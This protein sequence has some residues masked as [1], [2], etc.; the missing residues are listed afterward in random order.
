MSRLLNWASKEFREILPVW[1]FFFVSFA[2][3]AF[4]RSESIGEYH[5]K[6]AEPHEYLVASLIM[7]KVVLIVDSLKRPKPRSRPLI[8][9]TLWDTAVYFV[10]AIVLYHVEQVIAFMRHRHVPFTEANREALLTMEK[11]IFLA[12]MAGVLALTFAFCIV[13]E[14]IRAIG[15][16]RFMEMFFGRHP[17]KTPPGT[18]DFRRTA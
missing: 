17:R 16:D 5:I 9:G 14:L 12:L 10:A 15:K 8:Y 4:I 2:L 7:A 11:P 6:Q 3:V 18:E 13:R 1:I